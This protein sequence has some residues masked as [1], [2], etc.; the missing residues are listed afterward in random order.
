MNHHADGALAGSDDSCSLSKGQILEIAQVNCLPLPEPKDIQCGPHRLI[1]RALLEHLYRVRIRWIRELKCRTARLP[2]EVVVG[3]I[4]DDSIEETAELDLR[5]GCAGR[6]P[7]S[8]ESLLHD[9]LCKVGVMDEHIGELH[10]RTRQITHHLLEPDPV[11][12]H[13]DRSY[14]CRPHNVGV[15]ENVARFVRNSAS[16]GELASSRPG[17][18]RP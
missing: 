16:W 15:T 6:G 17:A 18:L 4:G 2:P 8:R 9:L 5:R 1:T 13:R 12:R 14:A 11:V 7:G 3:E 10:G